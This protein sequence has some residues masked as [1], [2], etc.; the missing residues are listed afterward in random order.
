[1]SSMASVCGGVL[2]LLD[3]GVP[4]KAPVA[5]ISVGLVTEYDDFGNLLRYETLTDILG[6][7]DHFGDMDFKLSATR[8]GI[9]GFQL[10]LKLP[11]IPLS[12]MKEAIDQAVEAQ[13]FILNYMDQVIASPKAELSKFA[14]RIEVM[15]VNPD[16]IGLIIGPGGKNIKGIVA[17][18]GAEINI[19]DDGT[20]RIYCS[21][22]DGMARAKDIIAGMTGEIEVD[23]IYRGKVVTLKEFGAFVEVFPGRDGLVHISEWSQQS[24]EQMEDV[25]K[26]GEE[27]WVKCIGIDDK[28]RAKLSRKVA[29]KERGEVDKERPASAPRPPRPEGDR[30]RFED[31]PPR[32]ENRGGD[33]EPARGPRR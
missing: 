16:K 13:G 21:N 22:P 29:M 19:E 30:P 7:E 20:V 18:T 1:S 23:K 6:S 26:V 27:V 12:I 25:T 2:S 24:V 17:E 8:K 31:R 10:D 14:P 9:T 32:R 4:L 15:K 3:A 33:R 11:G 5:G 28:G